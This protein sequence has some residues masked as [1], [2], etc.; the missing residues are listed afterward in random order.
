MLNIKHLCI[1]IFL[2]DCVNAGI[3]LV[4]VLDGSSS[5]GS[6]R[7]QL[8]RE[9]AENVAAELVI[10]PQNSLV[11]VLV[12]NSIT[13]IHFNAQT[14]TSATTLLPA[15]NPGI[16]YTG[17]STNTAAALQLL[18][19]SAQ[20][21]TMGLRNGYT[22]IAIVV[23]DGR[24]N[25]PEETLAA[26]AALHAA[27]IYQIYAA[28]LGSANMV[29][30]NAIAS[31]PSLVFFTTEFDSDSVMELTENFTQAICQEQS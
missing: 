6:S 5:I 29:E 28:G 27:G 10:G 13:A 21:G 20:D 15:L 16:P 12:F 2:T 25:D 23:T 9:F 18:L 3:D 7:F 1:S 26:A 22:Q 4:F 17:G 14:H 11:G 19:S 31:D 24:S 8:I 30:V